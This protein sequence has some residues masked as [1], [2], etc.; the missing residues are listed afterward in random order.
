MAT[1]VS[2]CNRALQLLGDEGIIALTDDN[3]RGRAMATA[4]PAVRDAELRR[5]R[6]NFAKAR[7]SLAALITAPLGTQFTT[8]YQLPND[9]LALRQVGDFDIGPDMSDYRSAPNGFFSVEGRKILAN[10]SPPLFILYTAQV[11]SDL[12][13]AAFAEALSARIA[14]ETCYRIT[15]S[16]EREQ[17]CKDAYRDAIREAIR[18]NAFERASEAATDDTWLM[19]RTL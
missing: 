3:N 18:A 17:A 14:K 13:D 19:A 5:R 12:F 4:Y 6:W 15:Q 8:E 2:I 9:C 1:D 10:F 7:A 11:G 16:T